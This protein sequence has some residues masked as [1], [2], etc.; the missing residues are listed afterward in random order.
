M[1]LLLPE[2]QL[3]APSQFVSTFFRKAGGGRGAQDASPVGIRGAKS[4]ASVLRG[5]FWAVY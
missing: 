2:E 3:S 4:A 5:D 1:V